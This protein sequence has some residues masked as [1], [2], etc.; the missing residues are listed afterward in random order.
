MIFLKQVS[1]ANNLKNKRWGGGGGGNYKESKVYFKKSLF[2]RC[3]E[4]WLMILECML[5]TRI[6]LKNSL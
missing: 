6:P 3:W 4:S 2:L 5:L 1:G